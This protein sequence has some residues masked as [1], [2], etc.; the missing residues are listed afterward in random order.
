M[1]SKCHVVGAGTPTQSQF[2]AGGAAPLGF[3]SL[4]FKMRQW[5]NKTGWKE[6]CF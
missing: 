6:H 5:P 3:H 1:N 2:A 4:F